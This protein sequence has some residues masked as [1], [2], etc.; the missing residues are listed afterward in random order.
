MLEVGFAF[1]R[2]DVRVERLALGFGGGGQAGVDG[3]PEQVHRVAAHVAD[4]AGAEVP[5]HVPLQAVHARAARK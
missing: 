3:V 2:G 1:D 5:E 4:L